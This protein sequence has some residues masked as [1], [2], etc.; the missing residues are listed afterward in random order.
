MMIIILLLKVL[1][2]RWLVSFFVYI[3]LFWLLF[4]IYIYTCIMCITKFVVLTVTM[5]QFALNLPLTCHL[6]HIDFDIIM[7]TTILLKVL[8][9]RCLVSFFV[10]ILLF[11]RNVYYLFIYIYIC[12][13][14]ITKFA[15]LT[16][17]VL[18]FALNLPPT[19]HLVQLMRNAVTFPF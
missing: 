3:L 6:V 5:L 12:I 19:C 18:Q 10:Y 13:I 11:W 16:L 4:I 17:T 2:K 15:G 8:N 1:N 14:C 7:I 9:K